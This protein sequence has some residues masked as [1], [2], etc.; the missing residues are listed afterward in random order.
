MH[1]P[2]L[3][4][5]VLQGLRLAPGINCVD[6]T[7]GMGGHAREILKQTAPDGKLAGFD[8]DRASLFIATEE[9]EEFG[10]RFIPIHD[11][12]A[13]LNEHQETLAQ[14]QPIKAMLLD[15]GLSSLQLAEKDRGFSFL[16]DGPLDMRFDQ[17]KKTTTAADLLN[18]QSE[19]ELR[20]IFFTFGEEPQAKRIAYAIVQQRVEQ[21]FQYTRELVELIEQTVKPTP[22]RR[23]HPA[24]RV[25]QA[26]RIA[27]NHELEQLEIFLPQALAMLAPGG[28]LAIISF[29]SLEDRIVKQFINYE[30]KDCHCPPEIPECRCNHQVQLKKITRKPIT[31]TAE[32]IAQNQR[33]RSAKLRIIEKK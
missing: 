8:R 30:A 7:V 1:T 4:Q 18:S 12:Y 19:E 24:T 2:V 11:S 3:L 33:A 27:V 23:I 28:R 6:G 14:V 17:T 25:F 15:L 16:H 13:L 22:R 10:A 21:P 32:E 26:L 5:E 9:L 31:A 29:H 20:K